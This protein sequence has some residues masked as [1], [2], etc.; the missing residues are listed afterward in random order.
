MF[1]KD[2]NIY[3]ISSWENLRKSKKKVWWRRSSICIKLVILQHHAVSRRFCSPQTVS[4][5][6]TD[7]TLKYINVLL[8]TQTNFSQPSE[9]DESSGSPADQ[10]WYDYFKLIM[11]LFCCY[12]DT[13]NTTDDPP[14]VSQDISES[15]STTLTLQL[16]YSII[17]C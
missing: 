1:K 17:A 5:F 11:M 9:S 8:K 7:Q 3:E 10:P 6:N 2:G 12:S 13:N 15:P 14:E 4:L 16:H